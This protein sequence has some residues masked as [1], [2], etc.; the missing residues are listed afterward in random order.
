MNQKT[1]HSKFWG[2]IALMLWALLIIAGIVVK[3]VYGLADW[4]TFFHLPAAVMLVMAF[5]VLSRDI[6]QKYQAQLKAIN[7]AR[8]R[9]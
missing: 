6:R 5:N 8:T 9:V 2:W 3:R 7:R 4:M 1:S